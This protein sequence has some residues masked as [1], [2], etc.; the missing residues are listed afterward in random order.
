MQY[1]NHFSPSR[2]SIYFLNKNVTQIGFYTLFTKTTCVFMCTFPIFLQL[3]IKYHF[4]IKLLWICK[5]LS[6]HINDDEIFLCYSDI[7]NAFDGGISI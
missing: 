7:K 3:K 2:L 1:I 4:D 6:Y 5:K